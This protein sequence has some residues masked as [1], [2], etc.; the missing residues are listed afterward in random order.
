MDKHN[1][2]CSYS[3]AVKSASIPQIK[4]LFSRKNCAVIIDENAF[5]L[6][7]YILP[8]MLSDAVMVLPAGEKTKSLQTATA[9]Y[10][11]LTD[12]NISRGSIVFA[13]GGGTVT[14]VTAYAVSTY[15]R[16]CRLWL[17]PTTLL[18]MTDA[19]IGGKTAVNYRGIKNVIGT[20]YPAEEVII[21]PE[22]QQTLPDTEL[23]NGL[24][25]MLKLWL[26]VPNLPQPKLDKSGWVAKKQILQYAEAKLKLCAQDL[27]DT[28]CRRLLNLGHTFGHIIESLSRYRI[29]HGNAVII[30]IIIAARMSSKLGYLD[31]KELHKTE[32]IIN[33]YRFPYSIDD[34][35]QAKYQKAFQKYIAQDK[36]T[37]DKGLSLVLF[38]GFRDVFIKDA[39]S[40]EEVLEKMPYCF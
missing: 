15:K 3:T 22:F 28:G 17:I 38:R 33:R 16:G 21:C 4:T 25:E 8:M 19:A 31:T 2:L 40:T 32:S 12:K 35:P 14:D 23:S 5:F 7:T 37:T 39:M 18:G 30:G 24:A 11:F 36:K 10:R 1:F 9:I 29:P 20:F 13:I 26:I 34:I 6:Y 27:T